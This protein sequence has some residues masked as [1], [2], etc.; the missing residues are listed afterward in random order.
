MLKLLS[1]SL[2][3][4]YAIFFVKQNVN[5]IEFGRSLKL[6]FVYS[7]KYSMQYLPI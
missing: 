5:K 4:Y 7:K 1:Q 3:T 2:M 6:T